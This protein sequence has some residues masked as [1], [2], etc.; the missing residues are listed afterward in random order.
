MVQEAL[1]NWQN[2]ELLRLDSRAGVIHVDRGRIQ[3][4]GHEPTEGLWTSNAPRATTAPGDGASTPLALFSLFDG[5]GLARLAVG[6]LLA[7]TCGGPVLV[8]S[9]FA[10]LDNDLAVAVETYWETR[11]RQTGCVAHR[12]IATDVWNLLRGSP[13]HLEVFAQG[14]PQQTSALLVAG[15]PCPDLTLA[16]RYRGIQGLCGPASVLFQSWHGRYG[17]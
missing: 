6:E 2:L 4:L 11:A 14:L 8:Q 7:A 16:S 13:S 5:T 1:E 17:A 9:V 3:A 10:E 12:R 15:S